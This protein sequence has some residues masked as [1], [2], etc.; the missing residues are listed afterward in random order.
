M[1]IL[2]TRNFQLKSP[3]TWKAQIFGE[4]AFMFPTKSYAYVLAWEESTHV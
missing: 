2:T 4:P 3:F 1:R